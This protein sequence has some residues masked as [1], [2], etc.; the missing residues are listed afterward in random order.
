MSDDVPKRLTSDRGIEL[1]S[2]VE[3][4][5]EKGADVELNDFLRFGVFTGPG[6]TGG[7]LHD[8]TVPL[9]REE[10]INLPSV[11]ALD[12]FVSKAHDISEISA[13]RAL[14]NGLGIHEDDLLRHED[15]KANLG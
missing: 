7:I 4:T 5:I 6:Y 9:T 1:D 11:D 15:V 3:A 8:G 10:M 2:G 12:N 14:A 13:M